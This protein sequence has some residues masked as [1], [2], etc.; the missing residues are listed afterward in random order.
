MCQQ[1]L[2]VLISQIL[3]KNWIEEVL[4]HAILDKKGSILKNL[5]KH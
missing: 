1:F 5:G 2:G 4:F 3:K